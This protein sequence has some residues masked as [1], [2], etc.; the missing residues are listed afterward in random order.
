MIASIGIS[1]MVIPMYKALRFST[2]VLPHFYLANPK[3]KEFR[4]LAG[5]GH[6]LKG[7]RT[8]ISAFTLKRIPAVGFESLSA[9]FEQ[10]NRGKAP[11]KSLAYYRRRYLEHPIYRYEVLGWKKGN[12][13]VG[14]FVIRRAEHNGASAIRIVDFQGAP[15]HFAEL[16]PALLDLLDQAGAEYL[17]FYNVGVESRCLNAAGLIQRSTL[18]NVIVPNH[19]EPFSRENVEIGFAFKLADAAPFSAVK[20]DADQDRPNVFS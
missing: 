7:R 17:D 11:R 4:L 9:V 2:G 19:F 20:G 10:E 8:S 5:F 15:A 6:G 3:L 14:F 1:K 18:T 16:G 12:K 13:T